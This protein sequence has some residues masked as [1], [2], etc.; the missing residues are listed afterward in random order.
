MLSTVQARVLL[1][2]LA[3]DND[4]HIWQSLWFCCYKCTAIHCTLKTSLLLSTPHTYQ[5]F[6]HHTTYLSRLSTPHHIP[7]KTFHTTYDF[8][9]HIRLSTPYTTVVCGVESLDRYVI[10]CGVESLVASSLV[11]FE[12]SSIAKAFHTYR[13]CLSIVWRVLMIFIASTLC[14]PLI[15]QCLASCP[16]TVPGQQGEPLYW[17][18]EGSVVHGN[19]LETLAFV[20]TPLAP[21]YL[22]SGHS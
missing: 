2:S 3:I 13:M 10:V 19:L 14:S 9:H 1:A 8:P 4:I 5:D 16:P 12:Y 11:V 15:R 21:R 18:S 22:H 20:Y 7:I 6:P 17:T